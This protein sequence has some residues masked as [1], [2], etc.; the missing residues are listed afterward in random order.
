MGGVTPAVTRL[1]VTSGVRPTAWAIE[2]SAL[3]YASQRIVT[4]A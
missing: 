3:R 4:G 2:P 1:S